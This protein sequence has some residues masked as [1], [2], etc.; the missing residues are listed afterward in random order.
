M[1]GIIVGCDQTLEWILPWWLKHYQ[2]HNQYP[3]AFVDL[4]LSYE[5]KDWCKKNGEYIPLRIVD[6]AE[7]VDSELREVWKKE[8]GLQFEEARN[9]WLKKPLALLKTPFENTV[10]L[11]VDCEVRGDL[12][13][14]FEFADGFA[15][16]KEQTPYDYPFVMYNSGVIAFQKNHLTLHDW[17]LWCQTKNHLFRGDQEAFSQMIDEKK[18]PITELP[19]P[20]NW[21]RRMEEN[22][23]AL[24]LHW[25]GNHGKFVIR[26]ACSHL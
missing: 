5:M 8:A 3:V 15:M 6:F 16:A 17:A 11:D 7:E 19:P 21:S 9:A 23:D 25:H 1:Q 24:I 18:T 22:P 2:M 14:I 13:P 26:N 12:S 20:F 4:G 10:W